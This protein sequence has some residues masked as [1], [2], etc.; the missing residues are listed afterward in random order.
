MSFVYLAQPI[1]P[2]SRPRSLPAHPVVYRP[3][4]GIFLLTVAIGVSRNSVYW[5]AFHSLITLFKTK[6]HCDTFRLCCSRHFFYLRRFRSHPTFLIAA[7]SSYRA[8]ESA[9]RLVF[10]GS[11]PLH[12]TLF[13]NCRCQRGS[14]QTTNLRY[15]MIKK[16]FFLG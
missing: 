5:M 7:V 12:L 9:C 11:I 10:G 13:T 15:L 2:Q 8:D 4:E 1:L 16:F 3:K 6:W 14:T